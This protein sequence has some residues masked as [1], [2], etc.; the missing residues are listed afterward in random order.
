VS[1]EWSPPRTWRSAIPLLVGVFGCAAAGAGA[2]TLLPN[3]LTPLLTSLC[4]AAGAL[5][6]ARRALPAAALQTAAED[7]PAA[8]PAPPPPEPAPAPP[9]EP[10][11]RAA[12]HLRAELAGYPVFARLLASQMHSMSDLTEETATSIVTKL[13]SVD[14][15]FTALLDFIRQA[16]SSTQVSSLIAHIEQRSG[17]SR[18]LLAHFAQRQR[19]DSES[20]HAHRTKIV[21]DTQRVLEILEGVGDI[22]RHTT[23]LSLNVSI[24]AARAG[25]AGK[26]FAVI[27]A[28][29]R[30]LANHA[31][32]LSTDVKSHVEELMRAVTVDLQ[33][34]A[35]QRERDECE[36]VSNLSHSLDELASDVQT[37]VSHQSEVLQKVEAE[38]AAVAHPIMDIMGSIQFQ[39]VVRQQ[40]EQLEQMSAM[41]DDHIATLGATLP[42]DVDDPQ[43]SQL[44]AKLDEFSGG[45]RM[46][47]QRDALRT[48]R[49]GSTQADAAPLIE[50]F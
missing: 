37:I 27:A 2:A 25:E 24:E 20:G 41:V 43:D 16:G 6:C 29:I 1:S 3:G 7:A 33:Q 48:A 35:D 49:G 9:A 44:L 17:A 31:Q 45:F 47:S 10:A 26:G 36:A 30:R 13:A 8:A 32:T 28:E 23:M 15:K 5:A 46:H 14:A 22:A 4:F 11:P 50:M 39:D 19:A 42:D 38:S 34:R 40:L 18:D 12:P 21:A